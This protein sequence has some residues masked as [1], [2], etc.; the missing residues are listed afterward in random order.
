MNAENLRLM[1]PR[2]RWSPGAA[3]FVQL[4]APLAM[5]QGGSL[6][7]VELAYETWGTL[8]PAGDSVLLLCTGLSPRAPRARPPT[9]PAPAGGR[10]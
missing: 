1:P 8:S 4:D 7:A 10:P 3:R 2:R 9:T 6:P 5:R